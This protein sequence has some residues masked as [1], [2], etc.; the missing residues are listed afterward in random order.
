[1]ILTGRNGV[2]RIFDSADVLHGVAPR[3]DATV[4]MVHFDGASTYTNQTAALSA[5]DTTYANN[6]LADNDD[7]IYIGS[8]I[9]FSRVSFLKGGG[10]EYAAGS[11]ALKLYY[12]NG[13]DFNSTLSG[14]SDGTFVSPDCFAQDGIV[15][16][17]APPDWGIAANVFN[18]NLDADKYY[19]YLQTTSSSTPDVDVD[20]LC[21]VD[22]QYLEVAFSKM[23]FSGPLGRAR[24]E[25]VLILERGNFNSK[26]HYINQTSMKLYE[27]LPISF[28]CIIDDTYNKND[29]ELALACGNPSSARWTATGTS[30]KGSTAN[31]IAGVAN[32]Q[33][34]DSTNMKT[35]NVMIL[36]SSPGSGTDFGWAY[37]EVFFPRDQIT[38]SEGE[39]G[40]ILTV[41]GGVYGVV[42]STH[43]LANRY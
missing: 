2:L 40:N 39:D 1:M 31:G 13:T 24:P 23:D 15:S 36:F 25:E 7:R 19:I 8:D 35:V 4:D 14:S 34:A 17:H 37:Y 38:V 32:P 3:D 27:P 29:I 21:P 43:I 20:L 12:F 26:A 9:P 41:A 11:G 10:A 42:E 22:G 18:A 16:F 6:L 28:S 33:F 5:D 30:S